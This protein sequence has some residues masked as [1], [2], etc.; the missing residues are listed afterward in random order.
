MTQT[1]A[2]NAD[3]SLR[4][5][6]ELSDLAEDLLRRARARGADQAELSLSESRGLN[7]AVRMGDVETVEYT[8]DRGLSLIVYFNQRKASAS[9]ADLSPSGLEATLDQACA[10]ARYT[11]A[12][13]FAG[14]GDAARMASEFPDLDLW[15]PWALDA[16]AAVEL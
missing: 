5:I 16:D 9:T 1:I 11:E 14:L 7:V 2:K 6:A 3:A 15:H 12:D 10:I 4:R 8:R 13:P